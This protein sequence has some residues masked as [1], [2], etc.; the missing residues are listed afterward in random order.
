MRRGNPTP[1]SNTPDL[2][3]TFCLATFQLSVLSFLHRGHFNCAGPDN[4]P[5]TMRSD[6][7]I[8]LFCGHPAWPGAAHG[9]CSDQ[10]KV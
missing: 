5:G 7:I 2:G 10:R 6:G 3:E 4:M 9:T 8:R 1:S